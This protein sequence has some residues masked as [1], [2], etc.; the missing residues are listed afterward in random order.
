MEYD[1]IEV[2][3]PSDLDSVTRF[4]RLHWKRG[5]LASERRALTIIMPSARRGAF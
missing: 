3:R 4:A 1:R 2:D 5:L